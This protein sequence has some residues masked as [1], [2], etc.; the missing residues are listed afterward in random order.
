MGIQKEK[1]M[2]EP[3]YFIAIR[4]AEGFMGNAQDVAMIGFKG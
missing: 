2:Y 4:I 1:V 3:V